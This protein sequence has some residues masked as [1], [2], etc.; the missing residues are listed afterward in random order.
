MMARGEKWLREWQKHTFYT[1]KL[2][3]KVLGVTEMTFLMKIAMFE[4]IFDEE[5]DV[6][7]IEAEEL[8]LHG[9]DATVNK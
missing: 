8:F 3:N 1:K 7:A 6:S 5:S 4:D 2:L 9:G